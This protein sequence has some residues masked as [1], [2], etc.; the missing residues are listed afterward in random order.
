MAA[1]V[2]KPAG[3]SAP[4]PN[5]AAPIEAPTAASHFRDA[6]GAAQAAGTS[7]TLEVWRLFVLLNF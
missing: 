1:N 6:M 7:A 4:T 5:G 3:Q 2:A